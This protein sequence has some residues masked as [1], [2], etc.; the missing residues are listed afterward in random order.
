MRI[1]WNVYHNV[2][3]RLPT[4]KCEIEGSV[5]DVAR[6]WHKWL[7]EHPNAITSGF[8]RDA[9]PLEKRAFSRILTRQCQ[10]PPIPA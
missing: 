3:D 2:L 8:R 1:Q 7:L 6:Q 4:E 10:M 9:T 5:F